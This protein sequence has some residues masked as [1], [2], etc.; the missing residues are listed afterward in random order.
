M[1]VTLFEGKRELKARAVLVGQRLDLR[2]LE[3]TERL[4]IAPLTLPVGPGCAILL[5]YGAVVFF[6]VSPMEEVSFLSHLKPFVT[7]PYT[8]PET[9]ALE[10]HIDPEA[11]ES[12]VRDALE[13]HDASIERL[14]VVAHIL[15]K[16]IVLA[17]YE[18]RIA[19]VG[20]F[21]NK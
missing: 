13:I 6:D 9:E 3:S 10:I 19:L 12:M 1:A 17:D 7:E 14:Q 15:A 20:L 18:N 21:P 16:S 8:N 4:A 5:R 2:A 11:K